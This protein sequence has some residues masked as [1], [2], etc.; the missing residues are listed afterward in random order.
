[1]S[2]LDLRLNPASYP[3]GTG[4]TNI[5]RVENKIAEFVT[6]LDVTEGEILVEGGCRIEKLIT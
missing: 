6:E 4:G 2:G 3:V 5:G 1:V